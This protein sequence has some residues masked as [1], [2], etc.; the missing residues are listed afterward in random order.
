[1]RASSTRRRFIAGLGLGTASPL[2][3][4]I[5]GTLVG[6]AA[7]QPGGAATAKFK[8]LILFTGSNGLLER[9][10]TC[11]TRGER[12]FDLGPI[13]H[14]VAAYK[15][16]M[17]I[18]HRFFIPHS[19][20][21]HGSQTSTLTVVPCTN[22][23]ASHFRAPPGGISIDRH[24]AKKIGVGDAFSST[25]VGRGGSIS[26]DGPGATF[27]LI[28][29][30]APAFAKYFGGALPAG[31]AAEPG[32][33]GGFVNDFVAKDRSILDWL[34]AD[35]GRLEARLGAPER[36]KLEQYLESLRALERQ[37]TTR[38]TAPTS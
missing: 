26:A 4:S 36:V 30:P 2:L 33:G 1:M 37:T 32:A 17:T 13:Y 35:A 14:P 27:P 22:P 15:D 28:Y 38:G 9:F 24:I 7:A 10:T 25:A 16:R 12:D 5:A 29:A 20:D 23:S 21:L 8:R 18:A 19:K 31:G 11:R 6:E 3:T 34:R